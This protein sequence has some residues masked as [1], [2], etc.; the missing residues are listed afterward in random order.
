MIDGRIQ[1]SFFR[2]ALLQRPQFVGLGQTPKPKQVADFFEGGVVGEIVDVIAAIGEHS[3]LTV[4]VA[5]AGCG[6]DNAFQSFGGVQA[7]NAGHGSSL[8]VRNNLG[9]S[10]AQNRR[11]ATLIYTR[12][13]R[14]FPSV[15]GL[16]CLAWKRARR[17]IVSS[18]FVAGG[19]VDL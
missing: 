19:C 13:R 17:K 10:Y 16:E 3:L 9:C 14:Q 15:L 8:T 2:H 5:N 11:W 7:R 6:S 18:P 4:D 12:N 1:F